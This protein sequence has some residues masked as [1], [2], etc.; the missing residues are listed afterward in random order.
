MQWRITAALLVVSLACQVSGVGGASGD[1]IGIGV[2]GNAPQLI[3]NTM[4]M[5]HMTSYIFGG[6]NK[7]ATVPGNALY[8]FD[9][10][11]RVWSK[12]TP[13]GPDVP[14]GR[15]F[16]TATIS[17]DQRRMFIYGGLACFNRIQMTSL[18]KGLTEFHMQ[19]DSLEY[20]FGLEDV[21]AYDFVTKV[22]AE[23]SPQRYRREPKCPTAQGVT[24]VGGSATLTAPLA[25]LVAVAGFTSMWSL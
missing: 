9:L 25:W 15:M 1:N 24:F 4:V 10:N 17:S 18:E 3:G 19:Q 12:V 23:I 6:L 5:R 20:S 16:H 21:W 7:S 2:F 22:W 11:E 8:M 13:V 14:P